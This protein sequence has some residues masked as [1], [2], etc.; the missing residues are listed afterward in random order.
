MATRCVK[1]LAMLFIVGP[2]FGQAYTRPIY[3]RPSEFGS[4]R[5]GIIGGVNT[6]GAPSDIGGARTP[7][8]LDRIGR[9]RLPLGRS[10][11][12]FLPEILQ[13][14]AIGVAVPPSAQRSPYRPPFAYDD[15]QIRDAT[16]LSQS[17]SFELPIT[18]LPTV[19]L[20]VP[21][22]TIIAHG[23][24]DPFKKYFGLAEPRIAVPHATRSAAEDGVT[25]VAALYGAAND[26][27][28]QD[29]L[30]RGISAF[31]EATSARTEDRYD[32]FRTAAQLLDLASEVN[33]GDPLPRLLSVH[34]ALAQ[35]RFLTAWLQLTRSVQ[36]DP[37]VFTH[38]I[39]LRSYF[40]DPRLLDEQARGL[41]RVSDLSSATPQA[42]GFA[43]YGSWVA[44]DSTNLKR[45]LAELEGRIS[46]PQSDLAARQIYFAL[47][48]AAQQQ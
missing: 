19:G 25:S 30:R 34:A 43:A 8:S 15:G 22:R 5:L 42:L 39:D 44:G 41:M 12:F 27:V 29:G 40:A 26:R 4:A 31:R 46:A 18:G 28:A 35:E 21:N 33:A 1:L 3:S 17:L 20:S 11:G 37:A 9:G 10:V 48:A 6:Q 7:H 47:A 2:A 24:D 23:S 38:N 16:Y 13:P 36:C 45:V 14:A 32:R